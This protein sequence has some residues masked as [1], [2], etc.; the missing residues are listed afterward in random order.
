MRVTSPRLWMLLG[1]IT[2]LLAGFIVYASTATME[3]K[4]TIQLAVE[5]FEG[6]QTAGTEGDRAR[7]S[8]VSG[9]LPLSMADSVN[10]GM[11]VHLGQYAGTVSWVAQL[12]QENE[13]SV[14][15]DMENGYVPLPDG[16]YDAE[17]VL[18]S[19]TPLSF[20]WN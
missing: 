16:T 5:T 1:A 6:S 17:L 9:R 12:A 11:T 4:V 14:I 2:R 7:M 15:V 8:I 13:I 10:V 20:L 19:T 3:N 18:E